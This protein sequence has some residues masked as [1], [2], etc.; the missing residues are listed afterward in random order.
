MNKKLALL[1][2]S[3]AVGFW[4]VPV[5]WAE[6]TA[7]IGSP[8]ESPIVEK[9]G[10][11][12]NSNSQKLIQQL[13]SPLKTEL[14]QIKPV[15]LLAQSVPLAEEGTQE[16]TIEQVTS[17]SELADV[18]FTDWAFQALQSLVERYGVIAGY[19]DGTY[20]GNRPMS[21]YEFA[22]GINAALDRINELIESGTA[23]AVTKE[24][25][26]TL[27]K[28][29]QDFA[30]E[31]AIVKSRIDN[32][33]V[34]SAKLESQQF[35]TTTVLGG[36]VIFAVATAFG[37]NPSGGCRVLPDDT[38]FFF[39]SAA[40]RGRQD[41][42]QDREVD[43]T[44]RNDPDNNTVLAHLT[45]IGL[46]TSFT[47]KDRLRTYL[48]SGNFDNGGF[49]NAESFNTYMTRFS[50]QGGLNN[51][52]VL[53]LL[54]YR[55][56]VISDRV[57][58]SVIPVGFSLGNV[59]TANSPYFDTG[60][61]SISRFGE[62]SPIFKLGGVLEAGLGVDWLIAERIRLQVAYGTGDSDDSA[63]GFIGADRSVIGAQ[64]LVTPVDNVLTGLTF[65]NAY[66]SDG[67]LGTYTG[68]VNAETSGLWS[69][70]SIPAPPLSGNE[71]GF[72]ACCR[73]FVGDLAART[74]AIG[75]S[76]QWRINPKLTFGAWGGYMFTNFLDELPNF[77]LAGDAIGADGTPDGIGNSAGKKPFANTATYLFSLGLSDPLGREG[78][79]LAFLF[80]MPPK[81]VDAG[82]ETQGTPVPFFETSRRGETD[83]PVTDNNPNL[84]TVG[85]TNQSTLPKNVGVADEATSLHFEV[86]YRFRV[87]DNM[88]ITPGLFIVT[89]PGHIAENNTVYV[90]TLRTT[91]R[92]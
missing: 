40:G 13:R 23:N 35:S 73:Y 58:L 81:L 37:G 59:L 10:V 89:N 64:L 38:G 18:Q 14:P 26:E 27:R 53:D 5:A 52:V 74:N 28:L 33:E 9:N 30:A 25:L 29:E 55:L 49:T 7:I 2:S 34:Q 92:F 77:P 32:L 70:S 21:R 31:L 20:R 1:L 79:L 91:F 50:Y 90:A 68:S 87:N 8:Q 12:P 46:E 63:G 62:A 69:G 22:A 17:V 83:V 48:T 61:G 80:G 43:C 78:D 16:N 82:P 24:D 86:F 72:D 60:R 54:E 65:V 47:G 56:P 39:D 4:A 88:F 66:T 41:R 76:L 85:E 57:V 84:N 3:I 67:T 75:A 71:S 42:N 19:P 15:N 44:D 36:E 51:R 45:R 11:N 6:E